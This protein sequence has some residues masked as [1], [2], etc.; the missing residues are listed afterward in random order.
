MK[1]NDKETEKTKVNKEDD[2]DPP[3]IDVNINANSDDKKNDY[4]I[5]PNTPTNGGNNE[6][7]DSDEEKKTKKRPIRK[8]IMKT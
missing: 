8:Q 5:T 4:E 7:I 1:A 2:P 3:T 6:T